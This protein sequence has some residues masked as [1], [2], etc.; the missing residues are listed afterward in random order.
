[1]VDGSGIA[2]VTL[3]EVEVGVGWQAARRTRMQAIINAHEKAGAF[4]RATVVLSYS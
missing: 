2:T 4:K 1:V 3:G